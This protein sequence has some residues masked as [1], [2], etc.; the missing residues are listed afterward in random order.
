MRIRQNSTCELCRSFKENNI[1]MLQTL[2]PTITNLKFPANLISILFVIRMIK[3]KSLNLEF[4]CR[5]NDSRHFLRYLTSVDN[6]YLCGDSSR[7]NPPLLDS[8]KHASFHCIVFILV[9]S[10]SLTNDLKLILLTF[11]SFPNLSFCEYKDLLQHYKTT[12]FDMLMKQTGI[13]D[14]S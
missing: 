7:P 8:N 10:H 9:K 2:Q 6:F 1:T 13:N 3:K 12:D 4:P 11:H 5:N 14:S